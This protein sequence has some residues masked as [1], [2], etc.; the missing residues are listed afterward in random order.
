M[1]QPL[2]ESGD[3][4][5]SS[6]SSSWCGSSSSSGCYGSSKGR[7]VYASMFMVVCLLLSLLLLQLSW[8]DMGVSAAAVSAAAAAAAA[9]IPLS[10]LPA[11]LLQREAAA[12]L[13]GEAEGRMQ[14]LRGFILL[15]IPNSGLLLLLQ[16]RKKP[17]QAVHT[18]QGELQG[19]LQ[20]PGGHADW[21]DFPAAFARH[22]QQQQ[23]QV[24]LQQQ[25]QQVALQQLQQGE[26]Q[27]QQE[28]RFVTFCGHKLDLHRARAAAAAAIEERVKQQQEQQPQLQREELLQQQLLLQEWA[29]VAAARELHEETGIDLR[30]QPELLLP[31]APIYGKNAAS[32]F[33]LLQLPAAAAAAA[34]AAASQAS[35]AGGPYA[36]QGPLKG[37]PQVLL[38]IDKREHVGFVLEANLE[39]AAAEV[40][41]HSK[42]RGSRAIA[43]LLS[44]MEN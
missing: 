21:T 1:Q 18:P 4:S 43:Q 8:G 11:S 27:Q 7:V 30:Q 24:L 37:A 26:Q 6:S 44:L 14:G 29:R 23:Q 25:Q 33:F 40:K 31:L 2:I 19:Y 13:R 16:N 22:K 10:P 39:A 17:K 38:R 3:R 9:A 35:A 36:T 32:F 20:L 41:Y 15:E 12:A 34:A 42:G 28:P 5:S